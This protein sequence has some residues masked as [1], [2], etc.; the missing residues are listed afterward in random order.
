MNT[1]DMVDYEST[2]SREKETRKVEVTLFRV[3]TYWQMFFSE[4]LY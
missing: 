1:E 3:F 4:V 2:E